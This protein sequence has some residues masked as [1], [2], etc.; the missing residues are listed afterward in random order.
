LKISLITV[1]YNAEKTIEKTIQSV[2]NQ[3]YCDIEYILIDGDSG[4]G[5][6]GIVNKYRNKIAVIISEKDNGM[7]DGINKGI[8]LAT[9]EIVGILNADDIFANCHILSEVAS[10]F[11]RNGDAESLIGDIAFLN[12]E[13]KPIRYYSARKWR[14]SKFVWGFMPPHPS[15]Y[16]KRELFTQFGNYR[17]DFE[18]A[19][20]FELLIRFLKVNDVP[21]FYLPMLMVK[22][23]IGGKSTKNFNSTIKINQEIKKACS[24][25]NLDTNYFM[26]YSKYLWKLFEFVNLRH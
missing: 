9:G 11:I 21:F 24:L 5:T 13:G 10:V 8:A 25:N 16:C 22:M 20:D 18:I 4:D 23:S 14:P 15:F 19:A 2:L 12:G 6:M 3:D 26:L 17:T 1:A 7:Y